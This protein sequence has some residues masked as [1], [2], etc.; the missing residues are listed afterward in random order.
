MCRVFVWNTSGLLSVVQNRGRGLG[1]GEKE[2]VLVLTQT[3]PLAFV[4]SVAIHRE[5]L[6]VIGREAGAST[7]RPTN[8][9]G[10]LPPLQPGRRCWTRARQAAGRFV[11]V[12]HRS[13][14]VSN[15]QT[16]APLGLALV[17][18]PLGSTRFHTKYQNVD[19]S[20]CRWQ[21]ATVGAEV[22]RQL[23]PWGP[24]RLGS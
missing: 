14:V 24:S 1:Q 11:S 5:C 23:P 20:R 6:G 17:S 4:R 15:P 13:R 9:C 18:S 12:P 19:F 16:Q 21:I 7:R 3:H 10:R 22:S 8:I 2:C